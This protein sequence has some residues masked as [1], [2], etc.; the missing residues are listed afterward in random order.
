M[1]KMQDPLPPNEEERLETLKRYDVLDTV[2][3]KEFDD[4][5]KLASAICGT[6]VSFIGLLDEKRLWFKSKIGINA[7]EIPRSISLCQHTILQPDVLEVEDATQ[8]PQFAE[9]P[10]VTGPAGFRFYAGIPLATPEGHNIGTLCVIDTK[11]NKLTEQQKE[12]LT[13]LA[14]QVITNMELRRQ[15]NDARQ[16]TKLISGSNE[17]LNAFFQNSPSNITMRDLNG[18]YLYANKNALKATGI[19][20]SEMIGK[21]V[22]DI[23]SKELADEI[24]A[25]D[26]KVMKT[27]KGIQKEYRTGEGDYTRHY[28]SS[29]FPLINAEKEVYGVG[30][31]TTEITE[32]KKMQQEIEASNERFTSLFYNSPTG[33]AIADITSGKL[34]MVNNSFLT[35][36]R[37]DHAAEVIGRSAA[38]LGM[39]TDPA[40]REANME[41]VRNYGRVKE[42]EILAYRKDGTPVYCLTSIEFIEMGGRK[43]AVSAFQD[44][45]ERKELEKEIKQSNERFTSLFY[46][47]PIGLT[48]S[49]VKSRKLLQVN[50]AFLT[51]FGFA[52]KEVIGKTAEELRLVTDQ[53]EREEHISRFIQNKQA[54]DREVAV[55][56]KNGE[57]MYCLTSI[58][59]IEMDGNMLAITALQDITERKKLEYEI[60]ASS[61]RFTSLFYNSPI[62]ISIS[63][64]ETSKL[65]MVN[66]S[67]LKMF[68]FEE[69]EV[70]GKSAYELGLVADQRERDENIEEVRRH[71]RVKDKEI[72]AR[73]KNGEMIYCLTSIEFIELNGKLSAISAF[74]D[75]TERKK[76][77]LQLMEAK[78]E[79]EQATVSKSSFLANMSHEIRTPLNAMLGFADLL[80]S[81]EMNEQQKDYLDAIDTSGRNLLT[82]INDILDFSKI[83]AGMLSIENVPFGPHELLQSVYTMFFTRAQSK[84][85]KLFISIDP[86]LPALLR[87]DP[88]RLNQ[89][90]INLI[91][92]AIKFTAEGSISI[93]CEKIERSGEQVKLKISVKDTGIGIPAGKI[94]TIFDRF[95]QAENDTTR[96]Y[97]GTGLGLSIAKKLIELQGGELH[98]N[99]KPGV[100]SEFYFIIGY[101]IADE[102]EYAS[103]QEQQQKVQ[104]TFKG[105]RV[106]IVED[107]PLNQKLALTVLQ[108]E[109]FEAEVA[110]NGQVAVDLLKERS[111]DIILMDLQ[112][113]ML[114]G[115]QATRKIRRELKNNT[116]IVAMTAN[117]M[118]G[119]QERCIEMGMD[120]Y[121][122]KPFKSES[123]MGILSRFL[124]G[125]TEAVKESR[126]TKTVSARVTSLEYLK[127]FSGGKD[128]FV[129]EMLEVFL[130]Q[131]P[132]DIATLEKAIAEDNYTGMKA[133]AHSLQTSL[134][135]I[136]FSKTLI[137]R[138]KEAEALATAKKDIGTIKANLRLII[139]SCE[140]ARQELK[141]DLEDFD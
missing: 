55:Y 65:T 136:G 51:M 134:G 122:T 116:P 10:L 108:N 38:E 95:T 1:A 88:T 64:V 47:S 71:G 90:L 84:G 54:K 62:G 140:K 120:D 50:H 87:G 42:K 59:M 129:K 115:Y 49:D 29:L 4:I 123:L 113:P 110:E 44:I 2:P 80:S 79:A 69:K 63:N 138:L 104:R 124:G 22:H 78:R 117:A 9:S 11:P 135:F 60:Q 15:R 81:T 20:A 43:V 98:V 101:T 41:E 16:E 121:I 106:L 53:K 39:I 33:I 70:I 141:Q 103:M 12:A 128:A 27:R 35:I 5:T 67:Y 94:A 93:D 89:V 107:N 72:A 57:L 114:D 40:T 48:I 58:E 17:L 119:E 21:S 23:L 126:Q 131:N 83:E 32:R 3:E 130:D 92:N 132:K 82:I 25:D 96:N 111:Y 45:T 28:V 68:G 13:I 34:I 8:D 86:K 56:K 52:E 125:K 30:S 6:P 118:A 24:R 109:G 75:I 61:E 18:I 73:K 112:M 26:E 133:V 97:G 102:K 139:N 76:I 14:K 74:Q 91:G 31:I 66:H 137:S 7:P 19:D 105:R 127:E 77:E 99:S 85:L 36:F 46:N 37:Y 100:G